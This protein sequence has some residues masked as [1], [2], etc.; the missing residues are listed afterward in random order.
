MYE[1]LQRTR[2]ESRPYVHSSAVI[3]VFIQ[4]MD[5]VERNCSYFFINVCHVCLSRIIIVFD[6]F[7][8]NLQDSYIYWQGSTPLAYQSP[9]LRKILSHLNAS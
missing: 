2:L 4:I 1:K 7:R 6:G 5:N 9:L 8:D 3:I